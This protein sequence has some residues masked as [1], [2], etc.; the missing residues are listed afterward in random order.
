MKNHYIF[1]GP[2]N[3]GKK[4][5]IKFLKKNGMK[6]S[7]KNTYIEKIENSDISI[8]DIEDI[9]GIKRNYEGQKQ[10]K[11]CGIFCSDAEFLKRNKKES[12]DKEAIVEL[13]RFWGADLFCDVYLNVD[14]YPGEELYQR[15]LRWIQWE[16]DYVKQ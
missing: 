9:P 8:M 15:I 13:K 3:V 11:V 4:N 16:E 6:T 14:N 10:I 7:N 12:I 2:K 5:I 1:I